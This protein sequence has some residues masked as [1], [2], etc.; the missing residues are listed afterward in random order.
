MEPDIIE[1]EIAWNEAIAA[2]EGIHPTIREIA[3]RCLVIYK[4]APRDIP[5]LK[6]A[7]ALKTKEHNNAPASVER[8]ILIAELEALKVILSVLYYG[9]SGGPET[10]FITTEKMAEDWRRHLEFVRE[11]RERKDSVIGCH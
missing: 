7:I 11:C 9:Q 8:E 3:K 5:R 6:I 1:K 4:D 2:N 10:G